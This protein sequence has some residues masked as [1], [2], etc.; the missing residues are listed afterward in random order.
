MKRIRTKAGLL[1][2]SKLLSG[3]IWACHGFGTGGISLD[4]YLR[5]FDHKQELNIRTRQIHSNNVHILENGN[6]ILLEGDAFITAQRG[7]VCFVRTADCVPILLCDEIKRVVAA[8]H[9]GWRGMANHIISNAVRK[10][11]DKFGCR[12]EDLIAAIGPSICKNCYTVG[13][14]V[15][16]AF[17]R[18]GYSFEEKVINLDLRKIAEKE[19][20]KA[21]IRKEKISSLPLCTCCMDGEFVSY[22]RDKQEKSRQINFIYIK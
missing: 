11:I 3:V 16:A 19:L 10:M 20:R 12:P 8:V 17:E 9:A 14:E 4:E 18:N 7:A 22:R 21:G 6:S 15:I 5:C 13:K 2:Q 1:Y